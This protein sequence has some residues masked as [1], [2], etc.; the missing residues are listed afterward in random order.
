MVG[1]FLLVI[2]RI[3]SHSHIAPFWGPKLQLS[4]VYL[5]RIA[6]VHMAAP[7]TK[8]NLAF[9]AETAG[10]RR[11]PSIPQHRV[12][13]SLLQALGHSLGPDSLPPSPTAC[14]IGPTAAP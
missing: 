11:R 8:S 2:G 4:N 6:V 13:K 7:E 10:L 1:V 14:C 3:V 9:S 12:K 5:Q